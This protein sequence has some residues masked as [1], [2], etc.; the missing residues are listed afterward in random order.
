V[1]CFGPANRVERSAI[2]VVL[3]SRLRAAGAARPIAE[4][5]ATPQSWRILVDLLMIGVFGGFFIVPLYALVQSRSD[6]AHRSR[7]IAGNNILNAPFMVAAARPAATLLAA[8]MSVA[9]LILM[10]AVLNAA[11]AG[12]QTRQRVASP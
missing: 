5:L 3:C 6:V 11:V 2:V 7:I 4:L 9:Q 8:G 10:T 12:L 1:Q